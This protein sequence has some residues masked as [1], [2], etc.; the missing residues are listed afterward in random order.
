MKKQI[1]DLFLREEQGRILVKSISKSFIL[2]DE[3]RASLFRHLLD[4]VNLS[5]EASLQEVMYRYLNNIKEPA[6]CVVCGEFC[7]FRS[8]ADGGY[9]TTCSK[10]CRTMLVGKKNKQ[11]MLGNENGKFRKNTKVSKSARQKISSSLKKKNSNKT[12]FERIQNFSSFEEIYNYY[13]KF[14]YQ[15]LDL[16]EE[17]KSLK[18]TI[19]C[20]N[21]EGFIVRK[22]IDCLKSN[23][24]WDRLF[25]R[26]KYSEFNVK[27]LLERFP[28]IEFL[29]GDCSS[30]QNRINL[31]SKEE[32]LPKNIDP[33]FSIP[34]GY[35]M[36]KVVTHPHFKKS[37]GERI[38]EQY[39]KSKNMLFETQKTFE[40]LKYKSKLRYDFYLIEENKLIEFDGEQHYKYVEKYH[41]SFEK[42]QEQQL[43]DSMKDSYAC[44]NGI[45]LLRI[46]YSDMKNIP[47]IIDKF[48][49]L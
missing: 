48:L 24:S 29:S 4:T 18:S 47:N 32:D 13:M 42:F 34:L 15:P 7:N 10:K 40:N 46:L 6:C 30:M 22:N 33:V 16:E 31:V 38:I 45:P 21:S 12:L 3:T 17:F 2:K 19:Y 41:V 27:K 35:L 43:K 44:D 5:E 9:S 26:N 39:L 14:N 1:Y 20:Y 28:H 8:F 11:S 49:A 37:Y 36:G 23:K 25:Y